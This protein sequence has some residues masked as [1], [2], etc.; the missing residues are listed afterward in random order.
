MRIYNRSE[1]TK[2]KS[3][4]PSHGC[5]CNSPHTYLRFPS[6]I[7]CVPCALSIIVLILYMH[8]LEEKAVKTY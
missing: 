8:Y 2:T 3:K 5:W 7:F 4:A 1:R 6:Q